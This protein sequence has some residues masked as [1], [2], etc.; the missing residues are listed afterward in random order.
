MQAFESI[1][2]QRIQEALVRGELDG[3][4]G[5]GKPL[6]LDDDRLVPEE[7]RMVYRILKNS[8]YVPAEVQTLKDIAELERRIL[9][10]SGE[11]RSQALK[12]LR[13][14]SMQV[15]AGSSGNL[16]LEADYY[17]RLIERLSAE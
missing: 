10:S 9:E 3:L 1:A 11:Q 6:A 17:D 16:Q 7:L 4:P 12:K 8:G 5:E 13:L 14:L 15:G 2:E